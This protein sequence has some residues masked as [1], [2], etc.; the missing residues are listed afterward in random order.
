MLT[1]AL[2]PSASQDLP[3]VEVVMKRRMSLLAAIAALALSTLAY[4]Q[5]ASSNACDTSGLFTRVNEVA[6]SPITQRCK[7]VIADLF[8]R[9]LA[10]QNTDEHTVHARTIGC[11]DKYS[12]ILPAR[13]S[14]FAYAH[15]AQR[16]QLPDSPSRDRLF[17]AIWGERAGSVRYVRIAHFLLDDTAE[18]FAQT[19]ADLTPQERLI[20]DLRGNQGGSVDA[21]IKIAALFAP[22]AGQTLLISHAASSRV[23]YVTQGRGA[24]SS[25]PTLVLVDE[26]SA[27]AAE[28]LSAM[29]REVQ[30]RFVR[31]MGRRTYGK[32]S[33]SIPIF[34]QR[35]GEILVT[36]NITSGEIRVGQIGK[37]VEGRGVLPDY[38]L[39]KDFMAGGRASLSDPVVM[40]ALKYHGLFNP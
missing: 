40:H 39:S 36:V 11:L 26:Q 14:A 22:R 25:T 13:E 1:E 15:T 19:I 16:T 24:L 9:A 4:G 30:P 32:A 18:R 10:Q 17:K 5:D 28:I 31:L 38:V 33:Y 35:D 23:P 6:L 27:S 12:H 8:C 2:V 7:P 3:L 29:M 21:A 34:Y 20:V 37:R